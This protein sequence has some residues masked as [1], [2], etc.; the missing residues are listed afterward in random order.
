VV[1]IEDPSMPRVGRSN[2]AQNLSM[3][4]SAS[5]YRTQ[6]VEILERGLQVLLAMAVRLPINTDDLRVDTSP[7]EAL[8]LERRPG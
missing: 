1:T 6:A 8:S 3:M 2:V 5:A 4:Q 7:L